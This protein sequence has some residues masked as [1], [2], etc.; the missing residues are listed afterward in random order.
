MAITC[1]EF[2]TWFAASAAAHHA[3]SRLLRDQAGRAD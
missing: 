3:R 2:T 1:P